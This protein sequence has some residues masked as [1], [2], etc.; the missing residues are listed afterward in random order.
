MKKLAYFRTSVNTLIITL[1]LLLAA[2][3]TTASAQ[4]VA[5]Q[6]PPA[7]FGTMLV[8]LGTG[9]FDAAD[10]DYQ[11][12]DAE[13][14]HREIMGR[15]DADIAQN[16]AEALAF[17]AERF[18][19]DPDGHGGLMFTDFM[20]DP[21]SE[22]RAYVSS[23]TAIPSDGWV[24]RDGGWMLSV[25]EPDGLTLGGEFAGTHVPQ[26]A[27]FVFGEYNIDVPDGD[28]IIIHDRSGSAII[29]T[30][31]GMMFRCDLWHPEWGDGLAQGLSA[32]RILEDGRTQANIRNVLTFSG[33]GDPDGVPSSSD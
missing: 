10:P 5:S 30:D 22:Y 18:G 3:A 20:V 6:E 9:V 31:S 2:V 12:P 14:W 23:E 33:F 8:Y 21:R 19:L 26:G 16:R 15:S 11:A 7:G 24:V 29:G 13:F 27:V 17:F 25:T 32:P 1:A 4:G 28:E